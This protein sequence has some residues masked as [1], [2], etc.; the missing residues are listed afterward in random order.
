MA[1]TLAKSGRLEEDGLFLDKEK[2]GFLH[3]EELEFERLE[4]EGLKRELELELDEFQVFWDGCRGLGHLALR[5]P[6]F[7]HLKQRFSLKYRSRSSI[8]RRSM[9]IA[10][11]SRL[12]LDLGELE[13]EGEG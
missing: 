3:E 2:L 5:C 10:L 4:E 6:V 8:E 9:S 12:V 13:V 1:L 11:G 7:P